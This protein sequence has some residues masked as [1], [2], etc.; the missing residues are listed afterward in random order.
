M[1]LLVCGGR[2]YND[3]EAFCAAMAGLPFTPSLIVQGGAR[4]ADSLARAWALQHGA[5]YAE[6]PALWSS[7]G[8][9]A[10]SKRN[11][12]MLALAPGYC[13]AMPGGAGTADMVR[14]CNESNITV[15]E[16]YKWQ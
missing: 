11:A 6:V 8:K 3:Y 2:G 13:L 1:I 15:W 5:H 9:A 14:R 16:P 4:G 12:A 7:Y 10:G